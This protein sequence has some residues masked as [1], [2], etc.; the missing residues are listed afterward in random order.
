VQ[1]AIRHT[2]AGGSVELRAAPEGD[3]LRFE[4]SDSGPG[5][6]AEY[7]PR[8]FDRFYRVPGA[9]SGGAGLGLYI[10]KEIVEAHGGRV[11]VESEPGRGSIFW[12]T[13]P[14]ARTTNAEVQ[15]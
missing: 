13:L 2:P 12:F 14:L 8:L 7:V 11:G 5:I 9:P 4:V 6:A 15:A 10:C 3:S 1:N